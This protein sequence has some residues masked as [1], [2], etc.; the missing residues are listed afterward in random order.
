MFFFLFY[1]LL[2]TYIVDFFGQCG[3]RTS[4]G[5]FDTTLGHDTISGRAVTRVDRIALRARSIVAALR[6][7]AFGFT[8]F[9][10]AQT[11]GRY[12]QGK[13][14]RFLGIV[15]FDVLVFLLARRSVASYRICD[16][17]EIFF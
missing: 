17:E 6:I 4:W 12:F 7:V 5:T 10:R 9:Y 13:S 16:G 15:K 3:A 11:L 1:L 2:K 8:T 14:V